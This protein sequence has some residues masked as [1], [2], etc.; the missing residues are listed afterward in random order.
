MKINTEKA[1]DEPS[2]G[3]IH[4]AVKR[5]IRSNIAGTIHKAADDMSS[6]LLKTSV[7]RNTATDSGSEGIKL[8]IKTAEK[9]GSAMK[10]TT[11]ASSGTLRAFRNMPKN[12]KAQ[13]ERIR[14]N[15]QRTQI[16][17]KK[18]AGFFRKAIS[19]KAGRIAFICALGLMLLILLINAITVMT[20]SV[21]SVLFAWMFPNGEMSEE[22]A[23]EAIASYLEQIQAVEDEKQAE[24]D[25][26]ADSLSPEYRYDGT[27]ITGL[28]NFGNSTLEPYD[29]DAVLSVLA[30][31]NFNKNRKNKTADFSFTEE[32]I[33]EAVEQF[34]ELEYWYEYDYC[35]DCDCSLDE[36]CLLSL[37]AGS[38]TISKTAYD[39]VSD[40]YYVTMTGPT[41]YH[42]S[43][44]YTK[45][46]IDM[47]GGGSI[48]G[49]SWANVGNGEWSVTYAIGA[50][51]YESIDWENFYLTVDTE[52]CYNGDHCYLYGEV[53]NLSEEEVLEKAGFTDDEVKIY[54]LYYEQIKALGG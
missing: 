44:L 3:R 20:T 24:I 32:E 9:T 36:D 37:A 40:D 27:E 6:S 13:I 18:T 41:Y 22:A 39:E 53:T 11:A 14:K 19:N 48:S 50:D 28:N 25:E 35:P 47:H 42:A 23:A 21:V 5:E 38:F 46:E 26:I 31:Q 4:T 15:I 34:Y 7:D 43:S 30:A 33:R 8:G 45:L 1:R 51:A 17:L 54:H 2:V 52:Y 49:E 12:T 29:N 16:A 10:T